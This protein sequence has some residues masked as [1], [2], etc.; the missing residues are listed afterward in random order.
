M[1]RLISYFRYMIVD[2]QLHS[3]YSDGYLTPTEVA[4]FISAQGVKVAAL[5]DHN[6]VGGVDEFRHACRELKIKPIIG[7]ELYVKLHSRRFNILWYNFDDTD[8][9]L[10]N[11]LRLSQVRR[12]RQMRLALEKLVGLGF[13]LDINRMLDKYNHYVPINHIVDDLAAVPGN[14]KKIKRELK[15]KNPREGDIMREYFHNKDIYK[16]KNAYIDMDQIVELKQWIGGQIVLCHPAKHGGVTRN[17]LLDLL[18][19]GLDGIEVLSPHHSYGAVVYL[20]HLTRELNLVA[21]GGSDFHRFEGYNHAIQ[22]AWQYYKVDSKLLRGV[23][24]IIG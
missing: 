11:I 16:L 6:T 19:I 12:R 14:M 20:Q 22:H 10:H 21:T 9:N 7:L 8:A 15:L 23:K 2:L 18:N 13:K 4:K 3:T 17:F 24:K 1:F 5:T